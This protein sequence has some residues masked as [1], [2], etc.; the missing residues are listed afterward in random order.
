MRPLKLEL[1]AFG[2]YASKIEI[3]FTVFGEKGIFLISGDT[4]SG[5]TTIFD[6]ISFALYGEGSSGK[7]KRSSKSFRSD[8]SKKDEKTY[9][10]LE[11]EHK[12]KRYVVT[13]N[14]EYMRPKQ[15]G[16]GEVRECANANL[17]DVSSNKVYD[18]VNEVNSFIEELLSLTREQFSQTV[19]IAQGDFMKILNASSEKRKDLFQKIFTIVIKILIILKFLD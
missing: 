15:R 1:C 16:E 13:R 17:I 11:F 14:P 2:P 7:E 18:G 10:K 9:V 12:N 5:K 19:M 8:F 4:G 3:D 6:A